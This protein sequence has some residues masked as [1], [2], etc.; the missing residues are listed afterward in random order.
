MNGGR[1]GNPNYVYYRL[2]AWQ[3]GGGGLSACNSSSGN[4]ISPYCIFNDITVGDNDM[5]CANA[6]DCFNPSRAIG[7]ELNSNTRYQ[8]TYHATPGYDFATGLGTINV[9]NLVKAWGAATSR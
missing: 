9:T 2:A 8:P 7:V 5:D 3:Y 4:S 6:I 1:Q